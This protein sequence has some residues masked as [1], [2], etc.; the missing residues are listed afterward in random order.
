MSR[1]DNLMVGQEDD[2]MVREWDFSKGI[3]GRHAYRAGEDQRDELRIERFWKAIGFEV[4]LIVETQPRRP[5]APDFLLKRDGTARAIC[6]VKSM[7]E[8]DYSVTLL[9]ED[10]TKT[11]T[12]RTWEKSGSD[13]VLRLVHRA[14]EQVSEWNQEGALVRVVVLVNHDSRMKVEELHGALSG[15]TGIDAL[16]WF[17]GDSTNSV[18][19]VFA[20]ENGCQRLEAQMGLTLDAGHRL[21][22]AA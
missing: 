15:V 5:M 6:E 22:L 9:H 2:D 21:V 10:G 11:T 1:N 7:G 19:A 14:Q 4:E 16:L 8:F 3:R 20:S 18:P 12:R 17:E 13:R